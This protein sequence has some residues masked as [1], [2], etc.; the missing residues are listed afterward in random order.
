MCRVWVALRHAC[1]VTSEHTMLSILVAIVADWLGLNLWV[2]VA[3]GVVQPQRQQ[4]RTFANLVYSA[5][6]A[7]AGLPKVRFV[8][9]SAVAVAAAVGSVFPA[10]GGL[11]CVWRLAIKI[12]TST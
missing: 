5:K 2:R 3:E 9:C 7:A 8:V 1:M 12:S 4:K 10:R 6:P 11:A